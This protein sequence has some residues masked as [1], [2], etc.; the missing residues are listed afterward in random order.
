MLDK[1]INM[2]IA[3]LYICT[4]KYSIFWGDFY[5]TCQENFLKD[6]EKHYFVFTDDPAITETPVV[7]PINQSAKGFP[8]DSLL[9]FEM[10]LKIEE[11]LK[12][13]DYIFFFNS[14][15]QFVASINT[16]ILPSE[17]NDGLVGV[18]HAG[19]LK[20]PAFWLP[21]ERNKKSA[22]Y[23]RPF[24]KNY[25]YFL[26]GINGGTTKSYL[27]L[28]NTC[29]NNIQKDLNKGYIA[30]Y[31][32]ESHI[33]NYFSNRNIL[34]LSPSFGFPEGW[35]LPFEPKIVILNK[36]THGGSYFDKLPRKS[37]LMRGKLIIKRLIQG[38][39]WYLP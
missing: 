25:N 21:F 37:Y 31:H 5:R 16:E 13:F 12:H 11:K 8:L 28:I 15:V 6:I 18:L 26:G 29:R 7:H 35:K 39:S 34:K 2:R 1:K 24:K 38:A 19:Y 27:D 30:F 14:N 33:N 3:I 36:I 32:D 9:R 10:F 4:G 23:I 17:E 22:A 20:S